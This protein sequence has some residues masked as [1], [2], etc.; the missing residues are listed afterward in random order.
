MSSWRGVVLANA[1]V[2][3][4][5]FPAQT[6]HSGAVFRIGSFDVRSRTASMVVSCSSVDKR[7]TRPNARR[8]ANVAPWSARAPTAASSSE[9]THS[10]RRIHSSRRLSTASSFGFACSRR[11]RGASACVPATEVNRPRHD[12]GRWTSP[13]R[14]TSNDSGHNVPFFA[15]KIS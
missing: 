8:K 13:A 14:F 7:T 2:D 5:A 12:L 1:E 15:A 10:A 9:L 11:A 6:V 3:T 4:F